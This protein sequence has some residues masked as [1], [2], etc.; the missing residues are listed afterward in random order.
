MNESA[1]RRMPF[2]GE[3]E[4]SVLGALLLDSARL[5]EL[6]TVL[7]T[8][9]FY[10]EDN[11]AIYDTLLYM[12]N[13]GKSIDLIT[14]IDELKARGL[15]EKVGGK[16]YLAKLLDLVPT[17]AN[18]LS[19]AKIVEEKSNLRKLITASDE[20][21]DL[22]VN[23]TD[24][25]SNILDLS[26]QK[27][28]SILQGRNLRS[29]STIREVATRTYDDLQKLSEG[30]ASN[31]VAT[32]FRD[33]DRLLSGINRTDLVILAARPGMGKTSFAL[34]IAQ[35]VARNTK[36]AVAIFSLEM[37]NEQLVARMLSSEAQIDNIKMRTGELSNDDWVKLGRAAYLLSTCEIYLDDS[38]G[39]SV[40][41]MK[42]KCR[43]LSNLGFVVIDYLQLMQ[44]QRRTENRVQEISEISRSLK[45]M[46][47]ELNVPVLC[48]SQLSRGPDSRADKRPVL[49][50]LRESGAIEQDADSVLFLYNDEKYNPDT[51]MRNMAECIV[52]KNRHGAVG[53]CDLAWTAQHTRF[54]TLDKTR[55]E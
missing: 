49:S 25:V 37:S 32:G 23:Q 30:G 50:D 7:K 26:E 46:A 28:F 52:S 54:Y 10:I 47:K 40:L 5:N 41:E 45:I 9:D 14:V 15:Y 44:S 29:F 31:T 1:L 55:K 51:E 6:V 24:D 36:K 16:E 35:N 27:I 8:D 20:I 18:I 11:G 48:L 19:Y 34:N 39:I 42:S 4:M 21:V 17:S 38:P 3:A 53:K 43:R 2:S 22:C 33:V 13:L 12:Y